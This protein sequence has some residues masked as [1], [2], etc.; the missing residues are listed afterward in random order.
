MAD[1]AT[2]T[3]AAKPD[4]PRQPN[5][6]AASPANAE[7]SI[8]PEMIATSMRPTATWRSSRL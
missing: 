6:S 7:P 5:A 2:A 4:A 3:P 8:C 1:A